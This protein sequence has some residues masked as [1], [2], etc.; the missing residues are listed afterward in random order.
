MNNIDLKNRRKK[1]LD[2]MENNSAAIIF[3]GELIKSENGNDYE[4]EVNRDFYYLTGIDEENSILLLYKENENIEEK[5][6]IPKN[7]EK[8][9]KW[10]GVKL[11][12]PETMAISG[13][14]KV[15]YLGEFEKY[16]ND[17]GNRQDLQRI[18]SLIDETNNDENY[19][20]NLRMFKQM[21]KVFDNVE[22]YN[23][24]RCLNELREVKNQYEV[25]CI[26]EGA[27]NLKT[28]INM[29]MK[30]TKPGIKEAEIA[31]TIDYV[32]RKNGDT[33]PFPTIVASGKNATTLHYIKCRDKVKEGDL[34]LLDCGSGVDKYSA[35]VSRTYP[36]S[37]KFTKLQKV[38]Y[39]LVLRANKAV[40]ENV[41]PGVTLSK[42]NDIVIDIYEDGLRE[43]GLIKTR[44]EVNDYYY[45]FVSHF[46]GLNCHDPFEKDKPLVPGNVITVEPGLYFEKEGI[47]IRIEDNVLVTNDG[48]ALLTKDIIKEAE[49]IEAFMN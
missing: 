6:F 30:I 14:E 22:F 20:L 36:V 38:L 33:I 4:F 15:L 48:Y 43:L 24:K 29:A 10:T 11:S 49:D 19:N 40:I 45:H 16:I 28:A 12:V 32:S 2:Y 9:S 27:K 1:V 39:D 46:I 26:Y 25:K 23:L 8:S 18:Y 3:S 47:G 17:I 13:I 31:A 5:L 35:D 44:E 41:K 42:L 7:D 37:G 21:Y 34:V